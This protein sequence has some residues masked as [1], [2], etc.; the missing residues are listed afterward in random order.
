MKKPKLLLVDDEQNVLDDLEEILG[1][2]GKYDYFLAQSAEKAL[3]ILE[4]H[5]IDLIISDIKMPKID[6]LAF[7][8]EVYRKHPDIKFIFITAV[9]GLIEKAIDINPVDVIE[10]PI[11]K[12]ILLH[13]VE[14]Y[15]KNKHQIS[16]GQ[17]AAITGGVLLL[18][19][20]LSSTIQI[21]NEAT[22]LDVMKGLFVI[23]FLVF[24]IAL[25]V[26][27][28]SSQNIFKNILEA[29]ESLIR[30]FKSHK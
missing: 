5:E 1:Y 27:L 2:R 12:D 23:F 11:R 30:E 10:K 17:V 29:L 13:K 8:K 20:G 15:F 22:F 19:E 9:E 21:L 24:F 14:S 26:R 25:A 3:E 18:F 16:L 4:T 7:A 28:A 6:G